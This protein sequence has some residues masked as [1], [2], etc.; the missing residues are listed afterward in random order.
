MESFEKLAQDARVTVRRRGPANT[1]GRAVVYWMQRA[2]RA[3]DNLALETAIRAA[4]LLK[5]PVVVF[6]SIVRDYPNANLRS[7][8]FFA[9]GLKAVARGLERGG[10]GFV[11]RAW[12]EN[13]LIKFCDEVSP[14][15]VVG[16]ENPI[17]EPEQWRQTFAKKLRVPFWTVDADA[18]VPSHLLLKE[19]YGARTIRPRI[20]ALLDE[21]LVPV[22]NHKPQVRWQPKKKIASL[23]ADSDL[24]ANL[25]ISRAVAPAA[26]LHGGTDEGL[27][28]LKSFLR[29]NLACYD[30]GRNHPDRDH[31]SRLSPY[32][33]F[34]HLGPHTVALAVKEAD[35]PAPDREAFLEQLIVRRELAINFCRFNSNYDNLKCAEPW[36][37]RTLEEHA[38]DEREYL[39]SEQQLENAETHDPLWNAAQRQM[40]VTGWMHGYLRMY[41]AKKILEWTRSAE[42]AFA[43]AVRLNDRYELDGRDP[44]GYAGVAWAIA[45]KHDR[46]WGPERP[47]YGKIRYMSYASTSRKFDGKGYIAKVNALGQEGRR[48]SGPPAV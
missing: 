21:F 22:M 38:R 31:T 5:K 18:I 42:E 24:L 25:P 47:V 39:Y 4:N 12:P 41:W 13:D 27:K 2:Q 44:N 15:L 36:A 8:T 16:D 45:G 28:L 1:H 10:I 46:A 3:V 34:G 40:V 35:A 26:S 29:E 14:C 7:Y 17:R 23:S 9:E 48:L 30:E 37:R 19:Q 43:I 20:N 32:L 11:L 33:H 6:V